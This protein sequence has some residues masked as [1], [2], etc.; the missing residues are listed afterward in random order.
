MK[1]RILI[2]MF[3]F[4]KAIKEDVASGLTMWKTKSRMQL[5]LS[6]SQDN[7]SSQGCSKSIHR[8]RGYINHDHL[9]YNIAY[10]WTASLKFACILMINFAEVLKCDDACS[11]ALWRHWKFVTSSLLRGEMLLVSLGNLLFKNALLL[12]MH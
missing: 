11:F 4:D 3:T 6:K 5:N 8:P 7:I 2:L 10:I 9:E 12:C 1:I